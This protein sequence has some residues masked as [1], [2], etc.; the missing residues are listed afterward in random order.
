MRKTFSIKSGVDERLLQSSIGIFKLGHENML[1]DPY[2]FLNKETF[3]DL[4]ELLDSNYDGS[5]RIQKHE[6]LG[7][8]GYYQ[9]CKMFED[10]TIPYSEIEL[11]W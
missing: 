5:K 8:L 3:D 9:G 4:C 6:K 10:N 11:R 2:I 1:I 7:F